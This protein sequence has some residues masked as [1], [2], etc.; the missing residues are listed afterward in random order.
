MQ[1]NQNDS[2]HTYFYTFVL[3]DATPTNLCNT[4]KIRTAICSNTRQSSR[5]PTLSWNSRQ[6]M[7][8]DWYP[9]IEKT[10]GISPKGHRTWIEKLTWRNLAVCTN[11]SPILHHCSVTVPRFRISF[12][13]L[14]Y[15]CFTAQS[16]Q[17]KYQRVIGLITSILPLLYGY[18]CSSSPHPPVI[19]H[20]PIYRDPIKISPGC[21]LSWL[22]KVS[23]LSRLLPPP[24][25]CKLD[26]WAVDSSGSLVFQVHNK[27]RLSWNAF[28]PTILSQRCIPQPIQI[29]GILLK[30]YVCFLN[31]L[32]HLRPCLDFS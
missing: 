13:L 19:L 1:Y 32:V 7:C 23:A 26:S 4:S 17:Q 22:S 5:D 31:H 2:T 9:I 20:P 15:P 30:R 6:M 24:D 29:C 12:P 14:S 8:I 10:N 25:S 11:G 18:R 16:I 28:L 21:P 3:V 27:L